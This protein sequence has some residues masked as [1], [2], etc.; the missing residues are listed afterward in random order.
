M[1]QTTT[2]NSLS[3]TFGALDSFAQLVV[4]PCYRIQ[5]DTHF[6]V[7]PS[8]QTKPS[9]TP[10]SLNQPNCQHLHSPLDLI[11]PSFSHPSVL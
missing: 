9:D 5:W 2:N 7:T 8:I 11:Q 10:P 6:G 1:N 3:G 4:Q